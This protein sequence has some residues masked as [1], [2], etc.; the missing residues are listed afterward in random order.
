MKHSL[1]NCHHHYS[2]YIFAKI[3][4]MKLKDNVS[5]KCSCCVHSGQLSESANHVRR[6]SNFLTLCM[7]CS[8]RCHTAGHCHSALAWICLIY[9]EWPHGLLVENQLRCG[10]WAFLFLFYF[11][12]VRK[13]VQIDHFLSFS[14]TVWLLLACNCQVFCAAATLEWLKYTVYTAHTHTHTSPH[15]QTHRQK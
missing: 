1:K 15:T 11:K 9:Q 5:N 13:L 8:E 10:R 4:W 2:E 3:R 6:E 14:N 7:L 12:N